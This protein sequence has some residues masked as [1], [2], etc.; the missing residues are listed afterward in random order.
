MTKGEQIVARA[1]KYKGKK[2]KPHKNKFTKYF[3]GHYGVTKD[4]RCPMGWCTYFLMYCFAKCGVL[5]KL[6]AK[7]L[8]KHAGNVQYMYKYFKKHKKIRKDMKN[9]KPGDYLFKKVGST[10]KKVPGHSEIAICYKNGKVYSISGN[11]GGKVKV[12]AKSPAWY[13]GYARVV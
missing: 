11:V 9:I 12:R 8:G 13:C 10:K 4:G 3:A 5:N 1:K 7:K 2:Y 6:P